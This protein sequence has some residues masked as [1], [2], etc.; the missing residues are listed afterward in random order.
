MAEDLKSKRTGAFLSVVATVFDEQECVGELASR[1]LVA[2]RAIGHPFEFIIVND[3]SRDGTLARLIALSA[4]NPE[5]RVIDLFRNFGVMAAVTAGIAQAKGEAIIVMD[6]DLQD[7]PEL[8]GEMVEKWR[9]GAD[10]VVGERTSRSEGP[11]LR[12]FISIYY[13]FYGKLSD[14]SSS[15][16]VGNFGL[17]DKRLARIMTAMPE[18]QRYFAGLRDWLGGR[19]EAVS[20]HRA[21]RE[22]GSSRQ[23]IIGLLRHARSGIVSF[24]VR[25]LRMASLASFLLALLMLLT[26]LAAISI[27]LI[28]DVAIPGWATYVTLIAFLGMTQ[29]LALAV[30]SE[31]V[32]VL[33]IEI[34]GRPVFLIKDEYEA[35]VQRETPTPDRL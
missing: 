22:H 7:P 15:A 23:G 31:Y 29:S 35:G 21:G 9:N 34:K 26:G 16:S 10:I 11:I 18:R 30:L 1:T 25:P 19:Q 13:W 3:G 14:I 4:E 20:Y 24:T 12:F 27:R 8:I 17:I 33:F 6:G 2:L 28:T 32:A 5:L